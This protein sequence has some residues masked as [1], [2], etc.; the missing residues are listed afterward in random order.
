[1]TI[2]SRSKTLSYRPRGYAK[3]LA[4]QVGDE[5]SV[6]ANNVET[7]NDTVGPGDG[8]PFSVHRYVHNGGVINSYPEETSRIFRNFLAEYCFNADLRSHL[9]TDA[10]TDGDVATRLINGTNPS[11]PE[12]DLPVFI[13]E[14]KDIPGL[15]RTGGKELL[16]Q[17]KYLRR[18]AQANLEYQFGWAPFI[19][20]LF[21]LFSFQDTVDSRVK[22]L[23][24]LE[25]GGLR[26]TRSMGSYSSQEQKDVVFQS[27]FSIW[28]GPVIRTTTEKVKGHIK[29]YPINEG[30]PN[31]PAAMRSLARRAALGWTVDAATAWE[32]IPW[33]WLID[34]CSNTG[35]FLMSKRNIVPAWHTPVQV[36]RHR[37]STITSGRAVNVRGEMSPINCFV[38]DKSRKQAIPSLNAHLPFL[39]MRQMSILGSIGVLRS[40]RRAR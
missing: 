24:N 30:W 35:T 3:R 40:S 27:L 39:N 29:W 36:M 7:V 12:V 10:P 13:A 5:S 33:S 22:E 14:L 18:G 17:K 20:D 2:R 23:E 21:K 11:R 15:I 28:G 38:E 9:Y 34:W 25:N 32:L 26:Y 16:K 37:V 19:S 4:S 31:T 1:M 8:H 6:V